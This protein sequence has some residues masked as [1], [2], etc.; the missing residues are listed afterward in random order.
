[1]K[2]PKGAKVVQ[3]GV[4]LVLALGE[5]TGH[6]HKV[7]GKGKIIEYNGHRFLLLEGAEVQKLDHEE[8]GAKVLTERLY[9]I[10][11]QKETNLAGEWQRVVD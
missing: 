1:M 6:A 3:E 11:P 7:T 10:D 2:L 8:H 9:R 4:E 5:A